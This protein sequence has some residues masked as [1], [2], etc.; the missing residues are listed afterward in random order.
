VPTRDKPALL[1]QCADG[2]LRRTDYADIELIIADN[3]SVEPATTALLDELRGDA[4]VRVLSCPGGFNYSAM[5]NAAAAI[6]TGHVVALLN[7]DI[8]IVSPD[9]LTEMVSQ[10]LRPG[11]GAVGAR[12][13]YPD[14]RVQHA[15][16]VVGV[17]TFD[18]G[19]GVAGHYS[20]ADAGTSFGY[21]GASVLLHEVSAVTA[22]CIVLRKSIWDDAGGL[23][24][25][26]LPVAFNDV[27]LCLRLRAR[28][29]R[30]IWTPYAE[31][32]H[33]ESA[34]RG[35][36]LAPEHRA[37]FERECR[38]MRDRWGPVLDADPFYNPNFSRL[39]GM[40]RLLGPSLRRKSWQ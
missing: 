1:R 31:L 20:L 14:G 2:L 12:L 25:E 18:D 29:L 36:D 24:A 33:H 11:I 38:F 21:F 34:S 28:G 37:R 17:G 16:V 40:F 6:A 9:W 39:D 19:P 32:I 15:G 10:A 8:E 23:N 35:D 26:D 27:D 3:D 30:I 7:N 5:N 4:R 22:A 13:V